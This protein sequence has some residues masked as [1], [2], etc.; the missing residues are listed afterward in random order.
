MPDEKIAFTGNTFGPVFLSMPFLCTLRGDKPRLVRTY[1]A[2]VDRVRKLGAE[3]PAFETIVAT[4]NGKGWLPN[5]YDSYIK[6]FPLDM[7]AAPCMAHTT[8]LNP[9]DVGW[10]SPRRPARAAE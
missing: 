6:P 9:D 8:W 5:L 3:R 2:S 4:R 10:S 7:V 1:L